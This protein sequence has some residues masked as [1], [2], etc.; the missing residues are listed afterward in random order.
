LA[1]DDQVQSFD[2]RFG[3]AAAQ[4]A[5]L[6]G[7]PAPDLFQRVLAGFDEHLR[8]GAGVVAADVEGQEV[9]P[10]VEVDDSGLV[11]VDGQT[12]RLQPGAQP[13]PDRFGL[14]AAVA[15]GHEVI[16]VGHHGRAAGFGVAVV[17]VVVADSGGFF[18]SLHDDVE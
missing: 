6:G 3:G 4:V 16:R 12:F 2:H 18:Y 17:V 1:A 11:L 15:Q 5:Q 8:A 9:E 7:Q 13:V 10:V 14:F